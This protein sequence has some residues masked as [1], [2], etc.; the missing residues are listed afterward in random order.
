[1]PC[2]VK[3]CTANYANGSNVIKELA[4]LNPNLI[5]EEDYCLGNCGQCMLESFALINKKLT[6]VDNY[7]DLLEKIAGGEFC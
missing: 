2:T 6:A 5:V 4:A 1:M 3:F 7:E